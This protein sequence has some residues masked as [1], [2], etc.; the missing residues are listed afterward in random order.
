MK[1]M[2][3]LIELSDR[4][5]RAVQFEKHAAVSK[6]VSATH[7]FACACTWI[8]LTYTIENN[9]TQASIK[10]LVKTLE[11]VAKAA[12]ESGLNRIVLPLPADSPFA[13]FVQ[14]Q[15]LDQNDFDV[16]FT[17][18]RSEYGKNLQS[19][20]TIDP[21]IKTALDIG[22][23]GVGAIKSETKYKWDAELKDLKPA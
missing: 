14:E 4:F 8:D 2:S 10:H 19:V 23:R 16:N 21:S 17:F 11:N 15:V 22:I 12:K 13:T 18:R 6:L 20:G 7:D 9:V 5:R 3:C 1:A